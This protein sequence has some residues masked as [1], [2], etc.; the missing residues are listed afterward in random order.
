MEIDS[1]ITQ[2]EDLLKVLQQVNCLNIY[3]TEANFVLI[4]VDDASKRYDELI[5]K[6]CYKEQ[7]YTAIMR[8][9]P[10]SDCW[11]SRRK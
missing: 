2:R 11:N 9:L 7:D 6:D 3:P 10:A 5:A 4:K 1:I 8:E